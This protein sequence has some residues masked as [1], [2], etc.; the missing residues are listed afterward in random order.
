[1]NLALLPAPL[2]RAGLRLAHRLRRIWWRWRRPEVLGCGIMLFDARGQVLLVRHSYG[3]EH[4]ALPGGAIGRREN[5]VDAAR[6]ELREEVGCG[7]DDLVH[8]G[9]ATRNLHGASNRVEMFVGTAKGE[10]AADGREIVE[11]R[12]FALD[13]LPEP[14][15]VA[16][17]LWLEEYRSRS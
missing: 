3:R 6:R 13:A 16:T 15:A 11:A 12:F 5:P 2:H 8:F 10:P 17:A 4:W 9:S 7:A 14:L 1:M